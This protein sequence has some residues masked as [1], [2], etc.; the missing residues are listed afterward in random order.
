VTHLG[1][2][3]SWALAWL[4]VLKLNHR[5]ELAFHVEDHAVFEIV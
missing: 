5:P 3:E 2:D 1:A 4:Y